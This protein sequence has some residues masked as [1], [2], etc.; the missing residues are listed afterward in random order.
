MLKNYTKECLGYGWKAHLSNI[1]AFVNY[2]ADLFLVNFFLTPAAT[3]IYLI[4]V[5]I[6]EKN[7][8]IVT[9]NKYSAFTPPFGTT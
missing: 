6:A 4:A 5:Q 9:G 1:L 3:G 2:R 7:M 8:D